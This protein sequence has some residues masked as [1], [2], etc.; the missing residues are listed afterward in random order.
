MSLSKEEVEAIAHL[1]RL[2][3]DPDEVAAYQAQLSDVLAHVVQISE[4]DLEGV[5]PTTHAV[6]Q[7]NVLRQDKAEPAMPLEDVL[8]NAP[9]KA[10][11]QFKI[12]AILDE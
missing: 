7:H 4:L 10:D 11:N 3:L 6:S 12:Q 1:A 8:Y 5:P 2:A 9:E